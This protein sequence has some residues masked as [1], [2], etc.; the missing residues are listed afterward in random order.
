ML[1][2]CGCSMLW[3][4]KRGRP[5]FYHITEETQDGGLSCPQPP[6]PWI[7]SPSTVSFYTPSPS[8]QRCISWK[9]EKPGSIN[10]KWVL[11]KFSY[12]I[13][14]QFPY[15]WVTPYTFPTGALNMYHE[16]IW[17]HHILGSH[18]FYGLTSDKKAI[19]TSRCFDQS[20]F[21]AILSS[22]T[23]PAPAIPYIKFQEL[24]DF[25]QVLPLLL[26]ILRQMPSWT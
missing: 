20:N 8:R 5:R 13:Q 1:G 11:I 24:K 25:S 21:E 26:I 3:Q 9:L 6:P 15:L 2:R 18:A 19:S 22:S 10:L 16:N 23:P 4:G 12:K 17:H 7:H 14:G